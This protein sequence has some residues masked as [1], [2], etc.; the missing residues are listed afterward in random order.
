MDAAEWDAR[1]AAAELVWGLDPNR[2]VAAELTGHEPGRALDLACGEGRNA[3]WL[4]AQ[5][6]TA[7]GVDFSQTAVERARQLAAEAGVTQRTEFVVGDV[8]SDG[9]WVAAET[10]DAV[11][12]A[13]LHLI[14]DQRRR[15]LELA[16]RC[17]APGGLLVVVGH[18]TLNLT[19]GVGGPQDPAVL[20]TPAEVVADLTAILGDAWVVDR[21]ERVHRA[22]GEGTAVDALV[23]GHRT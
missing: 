23:V 4:A 15:T 13:Y 3:I 12:L 11:V 21:A 22:V 8:T 7:V 10:F 14:A 1:Y 2:F 6:W 20:F 5:G 17:L 9:A 19:K 16:A 18:D